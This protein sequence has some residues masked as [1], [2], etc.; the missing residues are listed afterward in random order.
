MDS[1]RTLEILQGRVGGK[2]M[3]LEG[4]GAVPFFGILRFR[5]YDTKF[6]LNLSH[7]FEVVGNDGD[8]ISFSHTDV[9]FFFKDEAL[10]INQDTIYGQPYSGNCFTHRKGNEIKK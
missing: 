1:G 10:G 9:D 5:V 8:I 3:F 2:V 6:T 7:Y 4:P